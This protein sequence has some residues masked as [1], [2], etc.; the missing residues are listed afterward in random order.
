MD[1]ECNEAGAPE[2]ILRNASEVNRRWG[3]Q[4]PSSSWQS[5]SNYFVKKI[6]T[7]AAGFRETTPHGMGQCRTFEIPQKWLPSKKLLA[8]PL[9]CFMYSQFLPL[10]L[11]DVTRAGMEQ[12]PPDQVRWSWDARN[13][14]TL[15]RGPL[16]SAE[17]LVSRWSNATS[18]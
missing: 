16:S 6:L 4:H 3:E 15:T 7:K 11:V 10:C 12:S 13:Y 9:L 1:I 8:V 17:D 2:L 18:N 5:S 14:D